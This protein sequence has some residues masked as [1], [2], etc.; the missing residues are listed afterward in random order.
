MSDKDWG[1]W[2]KQ[3]GWWLNGKQGNASKGG[4]ECSAKGE[5]IWGEKQGWG[6][7][8]EKGGKRDQGML[9]EKEVG[10]SGSIMW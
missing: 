7:L 9:A 3:R 4:G 10:E 6:T 5:G 1:R 8:M 2:R